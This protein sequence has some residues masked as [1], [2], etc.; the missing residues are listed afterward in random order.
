[1]TASEGIWE[2]FALVN[3]ALQYSATP[4]DKVLPSHRSL[5]L[6]T[7]LCQGLGAGETKIDAV[8]SIS[9][10]GTQGLLKWELD[11]EYHVEQILTD[12]SSINLTNEFL[13]PL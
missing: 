11:S 7:L 10:I 6:R 13:T 5:L 9:E 1:M 12:L 8:L 2:P 4:Q 3:S